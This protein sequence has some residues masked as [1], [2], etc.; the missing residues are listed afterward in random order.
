V[1]TQENRKIISKDRHH[2]PVEHLK[3]KKLGLVGE[4]YHA[5]DFPSSPKSIEQLGVSLSTLHK[6]ILKHLLAV[7]TLRTDDLAG[8]MCVPVSVLEEP[9]AFLRNEAYLE[10]HNRMHANIG[11]ILHLS[12]TDR[13]R[14]RA[15]QHYDEN[16]Y[17]GPLP[18]GYREY[19]EQVI[20]QTVRNQIVNRRSVG[21]V[22]D[23]IVVK[24]QIVRQIGAAFNSGNSLFLFGP[25]G[26]GKSFIAGQMVKLLQGK[27][28][29][30]YAIEVEGQII[31]VFDP[32]NH[33]RAEQGENAAGHSSLLAKGEYDTLDRRWV[34]CERPVIIAAGELTLDMLELKFQKGTG[35][36]DAPLQM[37]ANGGILLIDDLGR[38]VVNTTQLLN[39]WILPLENNVDY[40]GLHTG[41]KIQIPFDV[42]PVFSTNISPEQLADEAFLRRL[43]YKVHIDYIDEDEYADIFSQ[44]C[45]AN[46]LEYSSSMV[47]FLIENFY[48]PRDKKMAA[49]HP[50]ELINKV[51]D[52]SLYEGVEPKI[53]EELLA[54]AWGSYFL[55]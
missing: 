3:H 16:A 36:Y 23:D 33:H 7:G 14:E 54:Q 9:I 5:N 24:K 19:C 31:R 41:S 17:I 15:Q 25:A 22:F 26:T 29:I 28:V 44:Y 47:S 50:K 51:I 8:R 43:G 45:E 46:G 37:K 38:Q 39:R 40:L 32:T 49:S 27:V 42:I 52:F 1:D 53:S 4:A 55:T 2:N 20:K 13:G 34:V 6:I 35:F 18:I 21:S 11:E 10:A 48:R 12:L 30:P